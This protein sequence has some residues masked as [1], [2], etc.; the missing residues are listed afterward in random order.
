MAGGCG[1]TLSREPP[2]T[3]LLA[4]GINVVRVVQFR[5]QDSLIPRSL[6]VAAPRRANS[7]AR[8]RNSGG[9]AA[10]IQGS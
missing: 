1:S 9:C 4:A 7:T 2:R 8:R 3:P 6:A 10:G 5:K